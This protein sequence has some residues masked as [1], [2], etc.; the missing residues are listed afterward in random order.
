VTPDWLTDEEWELICASH[1]ASAEPDAFSEDEDPDSCVPP[2]WA[3]LSVA[4]DPPVPGVFTGPA[5]GF[6]QGRCLD[7]APPESALAMLA[8]E[9][10]G[11]DRAF[12]DVTDDQLLGVLSARARLEARQAWERLAIVAEFI[13]RRPSQGAR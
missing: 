13:R 4:G 2:D 11:Q 5:A 6:G 1:A 8:D 9:A 10:S 12:K 7:D 3:E